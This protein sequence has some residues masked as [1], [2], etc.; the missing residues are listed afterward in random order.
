MTHQAMSQSNQPLGHLQDEQATIVPAPE[1]HGGSVPV[2]DGQATGVIAPDEQDNSFPAVSEHPDHLSG[3]GCVHKDQLVRSHVAI[4]AET[5]VKDL[6]SLQILKLRIHTSKEGLDKEIIKK[7]P[8][9][10]ER[11]ELVG[12]AM[13][14]YMLKIF[15]ANQLLLFS[16]DTLVGSSSVNISSTSKCL[17]D[18]SRAGFLK[19]AV[20]SSLVTSKS[21]SVFAT[22]G[23]SVF[24]ARPPGLY[25]HSVVLNCSVLLLEILPH[26]CSSSVWCSAG[27]SENFASHQ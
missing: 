7:Y 19:L 26:L 18:S 10:Q 1:D 17:N 23:D 11:A 25:E 27:H 14:M 8:V 12:T 15:L 24:P 4:S 3:I 16:W 21:A 9:K 13:S 20:A 5:I 6:T 22:A 2:L